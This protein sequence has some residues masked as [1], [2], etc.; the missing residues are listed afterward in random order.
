MTSPTKAPRTCEP[1][2]APGLRQASDGGW[3]LQTFLWPSQIL[4]QHATS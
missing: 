1:V 4:L 3:L 2:G